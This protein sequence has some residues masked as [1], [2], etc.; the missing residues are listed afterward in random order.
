[1]QHFEM[2]NEAFNQASI[3]KIAYTLDR[4]SKCL[5]IGLS[6]YFTDIR[7][8]ESVI[9]LEEHR[10][11]QGDSHARA[12]ACNFSFALENVRSSGEIMRFGYRGIARLLSDPFD[13]QG[14]RQSHLRMLLPPFLDIRQMRN[15]YRVTWDKKAI[16]ELALLVVNSNPVY[17][18]QMEQMIRREIRDR[19]VEPELVNLS[20]GGISIRVDRELASRE[21]V[22]CQSYLFYISLMDASGEADPQYTYHFL[23]R[24]AGIDLQDGSLRLKFISGTL[25]RQQR[26]DELH[27]ISNEISGSARLQKDIDSIRIS[28]ADFQHLVDA[29]APFG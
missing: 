10:V 2:Y 17:W 11:R 13:S 29:D 5:D 26:S 20:A 19:E 27:W 21:L 9:Q 25:P 8:Q 3:I 7:G 14:K 6:G 28:G 16:A 1:M 15:H 4:P 18:S 23:C 24:K 22:G 12:P